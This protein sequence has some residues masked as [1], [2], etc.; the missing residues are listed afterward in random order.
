MGEER[1]DLL[2]G[3]LE[4]LVLRTLSLGP[5][6]GWGMAQRIQQL[7]QGVLEVSQGSLYPALQRMKRKGWIRSEWRTTEHNRR[8]RYYRLTAAGER[9]LASEQEQWQR[10]SAAVNRVLGL[11]GGGA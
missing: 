5:M 2:Q 3:T 8:G 7:S 6:H 11:S 9:Q 1:S 4:L 10:S